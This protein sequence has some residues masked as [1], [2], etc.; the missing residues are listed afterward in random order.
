MSRPYPIVEYAHIIGKNTADFTMGDF[1]KYM[2]WWMKQPVRKD[3]VK[4]TPEQRKVYENDVKKAQ[5]YFQKYPEKAKAV[6]EFIAECENKHKPKGEKNMI[7]KSKAKAVPAVAEEQEEMEELVFDD[8][9]TEEEDVV[10][11]EDEMNERVAKDIVEEEDVTTEE[12]T[13]ANL[14]L[15]R[16]DVD[17]LI[18]GIGQLFEDYDLSEHEMGATLASLKEVLAGI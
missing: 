8:M 15:T 10:N 16:Q 4:V 14:E 2:K 9:D 1:V 13:V 3:L 17:A 7:I 12:E 18:W 11:G 5:K 6:S